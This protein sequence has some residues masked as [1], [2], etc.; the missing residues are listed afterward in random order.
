MK[1]NI[2]IKERIKLVK[3][4]N[5]LIEIRRTTNK[6]IRDTR[7]LMTVLDKQLIYT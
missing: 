6:T 4:M 1:Q 3:K 2:Y 7:R 5:E